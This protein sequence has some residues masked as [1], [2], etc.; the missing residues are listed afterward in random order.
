[1]TEAAR[2][3][4]RVGDGRGAE[5]ML[6]RAAGQVDEVDR[7]HLMAIAA[8]LQGQPDS[9]ARRIARALAA[10]ADEEPARRA[11]LHNDLGNILLSA[12]RADEAA[13]SYRASLVEDAS[14]APTWS[15]LGTA[16][17]RGGHLLAA[18]EAALE[19]VRLDR[20]C[21]PAVH[22]LGSVLHRLSVGGRDAESIALTRRWHD[23]DPGHPVV[24]HR[25]AALGEA[26]APP[27]AAD[28][29]VQALFD[30]AAGD[31]D[32]HLAGLGYRAPRLVA[33]RA[34]EVLG[35]GATR[36]D[37]AD[38][39]C[40]TGLVGALVRPLAARL[41]GCDLSRGMLG[42]AERRGC[43]DELVRA[44]LVGF[45]ARRPAAFDVVTCADTLC[46]FGDLG[47][48]TRAAA[49]ALRPGG[50]LV[51]TVEELSGDPGEEGW[52]LTRTGRYAHAEQHVRSVCGAA[53]LTD[54]DVRPEVL[55][56]EGGQ[57]VAGLLWSAR[58]P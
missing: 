52:V 35:A 26:P 36:L 42:E 1:M 7:Q 10:A 37:V 6:R 54:V 12:G 27:R 4:L 40:G 45:L 20:T 9:A 23:L 58:A 31:F 2:E 21:V 32:D 49:S 30:D 8:H 50:L 11:S 56:Q 17:R 34:A 24:A 41:V 15:N 5:R 14:D 43:Y 55:R 19:A 53:G 38:V 16:L 33:D 57:P 22:L 28:D 44:E 48:V 3:R 51:A 18:G 13:S 39:G 29:Y 47:E 46:Y 25:L